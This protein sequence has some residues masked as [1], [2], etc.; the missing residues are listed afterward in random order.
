MA[1]LIS[2]RPQSG[3]IRFFDVYLMLIITKKQKVGTIAGHFIYNVHDTDVLPIP[4]KAAMRVTKQTQ[5][6]AMRYVEMFEKF[7]LSKDFFFSYRYDFTNTLQ[8]NVDR[9]IYSATF[10]FEANPSGQS[11]DQSA[12]PSKPINLSNSSA[13]LASADAAPTDIAT[14]DVSISAALTRSPSLSHSPR[15]PLPPL[16]LPPIPPHVPPIPMALRHPNQFV[17]VVCLTY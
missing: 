4:N 8:H 5:P 15:R 3:F 7:D 2:S 16:P 9:G 13:H 6:N 10:P 12:N 1:V 14:A 11:P 17:C